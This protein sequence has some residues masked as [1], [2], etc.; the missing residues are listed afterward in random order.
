MDEQW[1]SLSRFV[2]ASHV[3]QKI[4]HMHRWIYKLQKEDVSA[5]SWE[6]LHLEGDIGQNI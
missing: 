3:F 4:V 1:K 5:F 6:N 2:D